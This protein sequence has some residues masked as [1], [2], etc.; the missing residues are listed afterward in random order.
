MTDRATDEELTRLRAAIQ[1]QRS[2]V[3]SYL[4]RELGGDPDDYRAEAYLAERRE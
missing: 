1:D 3:R 2:D 4:A